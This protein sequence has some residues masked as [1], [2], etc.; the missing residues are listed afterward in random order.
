MLT[1]WPGRK[2]PF[3]IRASSYLA[4]TNESLHIIPTLLGNQQALVRGLHADF[5]ARPQITLSNTSIILSFVERQTSYRRKA[6][7]TPSPQSV[8][9]HATAPYKG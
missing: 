9:Q 1:L 3:P 5:V 7:C 4:T 2:S 6:N 8:L